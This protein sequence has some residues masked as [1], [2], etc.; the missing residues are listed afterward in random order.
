MQAAQAFA[1]YRLY[2]Q[3][4]ERRIKALNE[5]AKKVK[6]MSVLDLAEVIEDA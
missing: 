2:M 6:A 4:Q 5:T 1:L 3:R